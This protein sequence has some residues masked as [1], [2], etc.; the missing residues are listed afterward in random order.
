VHNNAPDTMVIA[1]PH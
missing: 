1:C